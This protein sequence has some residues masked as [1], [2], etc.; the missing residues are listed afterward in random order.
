ML[1]KIFILFYILICIKGSKKLFDYENYKV[2]F[3]ADIL[4]GFEK[5]NPDK[6][7]T[8]Y[9]WSGIFCS[10]V[11]IIFYIN[12]GKINP[13]MSWLSAMQIIYCISNSYSAVKLVFDIK[14]GIKEKYS[15]FISKCFESV[16][17]VV[18][19]GL[20]IYFMYLV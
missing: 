14:D 3:K 16:F 8:A 15:N 1:M 17:D 5:N 11:Y 19:I 9:F 12:V 7:L 4:D 6:M 18:Y 13:L 10:I 2:L 20:A